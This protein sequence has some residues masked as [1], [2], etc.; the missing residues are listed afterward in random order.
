MA[1]DD[2]G[3]IEA[4]PVTDWVNDW[5]W[6]DP[7]W[8]PDAIEIF[9]S[10]RERCPVAMTERY[11]RAFMPVTMEAVAAIA[12]DTENFSSVWV[13]VALPDAKRR[14]APPI[15]SDPPEHHGHRRLL[16]PSFS[17]KRIAPMEDDLRQ[18]CRRLIEAIGDGGS[19]DAAA[20]YS[21]HIPVHAIS[22]MIGVPE[23]DADLFRDWIYRQFQLAPRD[24]EIREQ[25]A[26]EM[27]AYVGAL[28]EQRAEEPRDDLASLVT[29]AEL[30]GQPVPRE[31][32]I[33]YINLLIFAGIDTTWSAIGSCLWHLARTPQDRRRLVAEPALMPTAIE[34]L[35]RAYAPVTMAREVVKE[36]QINGCTFK[37]GQMVMLSFPAANRD[38]EMFPDAGKVVLDRKEN[39][40]AAFGLGIHRCIGSNLARMEL[41]VA[42][43]TF[44]RRIPEFDLDGAVTWSEGTVRGPRRLPLRFQ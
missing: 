26:T 18:Y 21:Q 3:T 44:L 34:E 10:V 17:P 11:G 22:Q 15:T 5:D 32:Q 12:N 24:N 14:P 4:K 37:P 42:V 16:L 7:A 25:V 36:T 35:L 8:G 2:A 13:S 19:A 23:E 9:N 20:Q 41:T 6:L 43:E 38:P 40:H 27:W 31:L 39:R 29:H 1:Y 33:G 28:L 30:D